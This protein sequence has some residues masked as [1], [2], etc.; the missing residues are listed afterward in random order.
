MSIQNLERNVDQV[1]IQSSDIFR[2]YE[3]IDLEEQQLV[4]RLFKRFYFRTIEKK[5]GYLK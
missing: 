3:I 1:I 2:S 4:V 5:Y